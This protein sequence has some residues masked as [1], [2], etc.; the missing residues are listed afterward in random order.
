MLLLNI[1]N[2][3]SAYVRLSVRIIYVLSLVMQ[4]IRYEVVERYIGK[5][6]RMNEL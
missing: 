6:S 5:V 2:W 3:G 4:V 1:I